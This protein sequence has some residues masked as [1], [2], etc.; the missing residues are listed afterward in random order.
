MFLLEVLDI[1]LETLRRGGASKKSC[2]PEECSEIAERLQ[3][4]DNLTWRDVRALEREFYQ[5]TDGRLPKAFYSYSREMK[6]KMYGWNGKWESNMCV[7]AGSKWREVFDQRISNRTR[8]G[9][10][11]PENNPPIKE[12]R[13]M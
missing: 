7:F 6:E 3:A 9:I 1:A 2:T 11:L 8:I 10:E 4:T 12:P 5:N 13:S